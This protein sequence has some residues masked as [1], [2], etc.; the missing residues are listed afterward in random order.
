MGL[1]DRDYWREE[2][3]GF[4]LGGQRSAVTNLILINVGIALAD[5]IFFNGQLSDWMAARADLWTHPWDFWRLLTAGFAHNPHDVFHVAFNMFALW[6]FGRDVEGIY[7]KAEFLRTY[8]TA[9]VV[10]S[11][12][13]VV[14]QT[15]IFGDTFGSM[16]GAS[17][18]V[19]AVMV[20]YVFHFPHR[21]FYFWGVV[22]VPAW[23]LVLV[24][25]VQD[26][27]GF[28]S[29]LDG[30]NASNVA[31]IAHLAGAAYGAIYFKTRFTLG[32]LW[33]NGWKLPRLGKAS[34]LKIHRPQVEEEA[35]MQERVD[36]LLD[37]IY[38]EGEA[39]L[40]AEERKFLTDASRRYQQRR[41]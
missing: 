29:S 3:K 5:A 17:G 24:Y 14:G 32:S 11:F 4:S 31:Y 7:G 19:V 41:S 35:S 22:P 6:L 12:C 20:I 34:K 13:W 18:A 9:V 1:Y 21:M 27:V 39:S 37:K 36:R 2:Q 23:A 15:L 25:V 30:T 26:V 16:V 38:R 8:L 33:P 28:R 40:S 10:A